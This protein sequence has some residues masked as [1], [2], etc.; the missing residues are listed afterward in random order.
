M[1]IDIK[2]CF[3]ILLFTSYSVEITIIFYI[4]V[5]VFKL[6]EKYTKL[7]I[8]LSCKSYSPSAWDSSTDLFVDFSNKMH[9]IEKQNHVPYV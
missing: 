4:L 7:D 2:E 8:F 9:M 1:Y 6:K 3:H 5:L